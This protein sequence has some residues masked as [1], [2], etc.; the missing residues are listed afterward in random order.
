[1]K[2]VLIGG[3]GNV[4]LGDDGVGPYVARLIASQYDFDPGV[5]VCDLGTP[6]IEIIDALS[7]RDAV[8]LLDSLELDATAGTL[9]LYRKDEIQRQGPSE[10]I[11]PHSPALVD[12]LLNAEFFGVGPKDVLLIGIVGE[13]YEPSCQLSDTL[14]RSLLPV[15]AEVLRE[16]DRLGID[17]R[18]KVEDDDPG[19]WWEA[20]ENH[21]AVLRVSN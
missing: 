16:L 12:A 13:S 21:A 10:R 14:Q 6:A 4:L 11:D 18:R 19:I 3:I 2:R 20:V 9:R 8:I 17:Y 15:V 7:A 5:E 1:V